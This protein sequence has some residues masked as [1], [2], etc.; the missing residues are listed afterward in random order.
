[1]SRRGLGA[2]TAA[3][4]LTAAVIG[5]SQSARASDWTVIEE[6]GDTGISTRAEAMAV[7]GDARL[8]IGCTGS[9]LL[10]VSLEYLGYESGAPAL[11]VGYRVD[12]RN[13]IV[14]RWPREDS[15]DALLLYNSNRTFVQELARRV[16]RGRWLSVTVEV[17]PELRF[18]LSGSESPVTTVAGLCSRGE[19]PSEE[20]NEA[21]DEDSEA[22]SDEGTSASE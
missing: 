2:V 8:A 17:L 12:S 16:A 1:M 11:T 10:Y 9:G 15:F 18:S 7:S 14:T 13:N 5:A 22:V 4:A 6:V 3:I 20:E 21:A 19:S